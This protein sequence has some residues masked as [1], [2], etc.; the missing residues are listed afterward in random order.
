MV[1]SRGSL[2]HDGG[3]VDSPLSRGQG[4]HWVTCLYPADNRFGCARNY[5]AFPLKLALG[6]RKCQARM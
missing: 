1:S 6:H 3:G 4:S 5:L 2:V